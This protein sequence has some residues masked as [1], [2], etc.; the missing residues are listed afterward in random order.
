[1]TPS[2]TPLGLLPGPRDYLE[3]T[4][5]GHSHPGSQGEPEAP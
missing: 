2:R 1:M 3:A 5:Q 4:V